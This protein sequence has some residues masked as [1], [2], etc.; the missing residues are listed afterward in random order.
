[1]PQEIKAAL[2]HTKANQAMDLMQ[3]RVC[4]RQGCDCICKKVFMCWGMFECESA[5]F[6]LVIGLQ[7]YRECIERE[8]PSGLAAL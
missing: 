5:S 4:L 7:R 2:R 1:M 6:V 8:A 3:M